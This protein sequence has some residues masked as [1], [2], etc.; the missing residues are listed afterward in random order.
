MTDKVKSVISGILE[1]F[2]DGSKLPQAISIIQFPIFDFPMNKWSMLNKLTC[3]LTGLTDFRG[4]RQWQEVGRAVKRGEKATYILV[5]WLKKDEENEEKIRLAGFM[6]KPVFSVEQTEGEL[7]EY[8]KLELP[9]FPLLDKAKEWGVSVKAISGNEIRDGYFSPARNEIGIA[10]AEESVFF[11]ELSH[12]AQLK[13]YGSLKKGQEP[14]QEISAELS[15]CVLCY[16]VGKDGSKHLGN[17]YAYIDY[18]SSKLGIS[19]V[20]AC[21]KVISEV[22]KII[23]LIFQNKEN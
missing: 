20:S 11:H 19:P 4:Y 16:I 12:A 7:L 8:Q 21:L 13:L 3:L 15:A 10:T 1:L 23:N 14:L 22:E 9:E 18:Y 6:A 2:K 17:H 5:P